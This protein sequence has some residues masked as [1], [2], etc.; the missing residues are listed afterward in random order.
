[1]YEITASS[2][3]VAF[4]KEAESTETDQRMIGKGYAFENYGEVEIDW[5]GREVKLILN[6]NAGNEMRAVTVPFDEIKAG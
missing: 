3:N 4:A 1:M 5:E 2:L 6:D